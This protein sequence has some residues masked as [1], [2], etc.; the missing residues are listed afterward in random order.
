MNA[1]Q[2]L[3]RLAL[4]CSGAMCMAPGCDG[5]VL[6]DSTFRLWCGD[7]LCDWHTD[8]GHVKQASTWHPDDYGVELVDAPTQISQDT[9]EG[10]P[11]MEFSA[12][13][14]VDVASQTKIQVDWNADGVVD[15]ESPVA[16]THWGRTST[17]VFAPD[18][19]GSELRFIVR[20]DGGGRAVLAEMRLRVV[21]TCTGARPT[22]RHVASGSACAA[23]AECESG[24]CVRNQAPLG[25]CQ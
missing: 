12:V 17:L 4:V 15:F 18:G 6:A 25:K 24:T 2:I 19:W 1:R 23:D 9:K 14:D 13:A 7:A 21:Q 11:C 22:L 8:A 5:D 10:A 3:L 16:A 20:K